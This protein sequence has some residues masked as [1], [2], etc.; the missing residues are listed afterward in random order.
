MSIA[1]SSRFDGRTS[2]VRLGP[3][4][5]GNQSRSDSSDDAACPVI[6]RS[7]ES[8]LKRYSILTIALPDSHHGVTRYPRATTVATISDYYV[9]ATYW[10]K[11]P[12]QTAGN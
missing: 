1:Q 5:P 3:S 7:E 6:T 9:S 2:L 12:Y 10:M 11:A 4:W 8:S